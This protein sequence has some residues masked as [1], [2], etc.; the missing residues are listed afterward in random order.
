MKSVNI[1]LSKLIIILFLIIFALYIFNNQENMM[2]QNDNTQDR[3][4]DA[5]IYAKSFIGITYRWFKETDKVQGDDKI[6]AAN[7]P[8]ITAEEIKEKN[9]SINCVG[10]INLIRRYMGL[11]IPGLDGKEGEIGQIFPG[12]TWTWFNY[13][14]RTNRLE[15]I[16]FNSKY[17]IGTLLISDFKNFN[18]PGHVAIIINKFGKNVKEQYILHSYS[19]YNYKDSMNMNNVGTTGI[20]KMDNDNILDWFEVTHICLPDNWLLKD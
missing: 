11:S 14:N 6:W 18:K 5:L 2:I 16:N 12:T 20:Q 1:L 10:L 8:I 19:Y 15:K 13:L 3:I 17:D 7:E 9:K 4:N